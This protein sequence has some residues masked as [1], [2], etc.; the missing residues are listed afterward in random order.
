MK[1]QK[2]LLGLLGAGALAAGLLAAYGSTLPTTWSVERKVDIAA[3]PED[4]FPL[5]NSPA[6]WKEWAAGDGPEA[7]QMNFTTFGPA[8]GVGAGYKW[9]SPGS[10]GEMTLTESDPATGVRYAM[11]MERSQ[12]PAAGS[13]HYAVRGDHLELV[14]HDEGDLG[15]WPIGGYFVGMMNEQLGRHVEGALGLLKKGA[16]RAAAQRLAGT[17]VAPGERPPELPPLGG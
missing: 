9:D 4:V 11:K 7:G 16:E 8:E 17:P 3:M 5:L 12:S 10:F 1:L 2:I 15:M 6:R 13:L 14:W